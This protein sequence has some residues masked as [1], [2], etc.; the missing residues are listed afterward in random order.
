MTTH[1]VTGGT[2]FVG[3]AIVLELLERA[4]DHVIALARPGDRGAHARVHAS[5]RHAAKAYGRD[6]D[7]LP[8]HRLLG[9]AG[10]VTRP[11][12]GVED[13]SLR[14]TMLWHSAGSLRYED[15]YADEIITTNVQGT[16]HAIDLAR[17]AGVEVINT[18]STAYVAGA[19]QGWLLEEPQDNP[20]SQNHYERSKVR[21]E[22]LARSAGDLA[23]RVFR[24]SIVVGH[25]KTL[26]ATT[27]S[28]FYGFARQMVQFRGVLE[29]LQRGLYRRQPVRMR[30]SPNA[31][32]N[33]VPV[34][35]VAAQAV[36]IGLSPAASGIYHLTQPEEP[37]IGEAIRAIA[38][39]VGFADPEFVAADAPLE[40]LDEQFDKRLD[41]YGSYVRGHRSFDRSRTDAALGDRPDLRRPLPPL[42]DL[43]DWYLVRLAE[44]R[45]H[46]P[47]AR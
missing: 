43:V 20:V 35:A 21:A 38:A 32:L 46:L 31:P 4:D 7:T 44:E 18:F 19:R 13:H 40:W 5:V 45:R 11:F 27:F 36:Q 25:S 17:R 23:V 1:I 15:R 22:A 10:D 12:C 9:I 30:I 29:R 42:R 8:M 6:P 24:P 28:G 33:L 39:G 16:Q 3:G 41:F 14:A 34:D 47:A 26:A 37:T 2:G